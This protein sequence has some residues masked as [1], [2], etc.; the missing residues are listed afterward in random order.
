MVEGGMV[1]EC[2]ILVMLVIVAV[3]MLCLGNN[4]GKKYLSGSEC[5]ELW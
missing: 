3:V 1:Q 5:R 4:N 2:D